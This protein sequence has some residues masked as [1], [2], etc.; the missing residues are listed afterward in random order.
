MAT[1]LLEGRGCLAYSWL[2]LALRSCGPSGLPVS[3][4]D[5]S[6][7]NGIHVM[8]CSILTALAH[9]LEVEVPVDPFA[10]ESIAVSLTLCVFILIVHT[11]EGSLSLSSPSD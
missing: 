11:R 8:P 7:Y 9:Q 2:Q 3:A 10:L 4:M 5:L 6:G 1:S